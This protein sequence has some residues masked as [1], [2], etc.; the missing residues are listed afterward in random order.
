MGVPPRLTNS[1]VMPSA[2][3][4]SLTR[5]MNAGGK[6]YSRPHSNPIF[7]PSLAAAVSAQ[8]LVNTG[9]SLRVSCQWVTGPIMTPEVHSFIILSTA[10]PNAGTLG[11]ELET[12]RKSVG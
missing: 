1:A 5:P 11:F 10:C 7:I 4:R 2:L 12:D 8:V 9:D 3:P 6:L